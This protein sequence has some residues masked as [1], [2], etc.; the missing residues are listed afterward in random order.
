MKLASPSTS[1]QPSSHRNS[2]Q[3]HRRAWLALAL[4][5]P[6]ASLGT[7][8]SMFVAPG[9]IGQIAIVGC[10]L[11]LFACPLLWTIWGDRQIPSLRKT[12]R[13]KGIAL[14]VVLGGI[15]FGAIMALYFYL[16]KPLLNV[17][18]IRAK[19]QLIGFNSPVKLVLAGTYVSLIN[20]LIEEYLW[21]WF[22]HRKCEDLVSKP[23]AVWLSAFCFTLHHIFILLAYSR[24]WRIVGIGTLAVFIAGAIWARCFQVYRSVWPGYISHAAADCALVIISWDVLFG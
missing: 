16:G 15:M 13:P 12:F 23:Q 11:W 21:R 4:I 14:G 10:G 3:S 7:I 5:V 6:V 9:P 2:K 22:V 19:A 1:F 8:L 20:A 18:E 24:D 17:A